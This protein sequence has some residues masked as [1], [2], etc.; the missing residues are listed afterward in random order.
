[1]ILNSHFTQHSFLE[2]D[3]LISCQYFVTFY[4]DSSDYN[5]I[6]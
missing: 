4:D 5:R 2:Y 6:Q 1:M 3:D